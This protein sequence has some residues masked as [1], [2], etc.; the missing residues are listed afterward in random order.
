MKFKKQNMKPTIY[1]AGTAIMLA[2]FFIACG[3]SQK[4]DKKTELQNL[5]DEQAKLGEKIQKLEEEIA[6]TSPD[7][8][9]AKAKLIGVLDLSKQS[10]NHYIDLQGRVTTDNIYHVTPRGLGGQVT[11]IYVKEGD[12]VKKG[13]LILKTDDAIIRQQIEQ[14]KIQQ[15]YVKDIYARRKNLWDQNIGSEVEVITA[16]SNVDNA[17]KQLALLN[18]QLKMSNVYS[19]VAGVVESVTIRLGETFSGASAAQAG[20]SI[21]NKSNLKGTV[22]IPENYLGKVSTGTPVIVEVPDINKKYQTSVTRVSQLISNNSRSFTTEV[23]LPADPALKPNQLALVKLRDYAV[24][25]TIVVPLATIQTDEKGKYVFVVANEK[26]K[27]VARKR[28]VQVGDIYGEN[29]EIKQ[30]LNEGDQLISQGFQSLYDGQLVTT[31]QK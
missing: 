21:V 27:K 8:A 2:L 14:A 16:K 6:R 22:E 10:F 5:K 28:Q 18:E 26:G 25:N 19:E 17:D 30:G 4:E 24:A 1:K 7:S 11:A 15:A 31:E 13:Q 20:V 29:I 23:K 3:S 12:P 9:A